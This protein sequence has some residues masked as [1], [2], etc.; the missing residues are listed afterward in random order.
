MSKPPIHWRQ[1]NGGFRE[2]WEGFRTYADGE[3]KVGY[4]VAFGP[5]IWTPGI[6]HADGTDTPLIAVDSLA[7]GQSVVQ[8]KAEL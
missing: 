1:K 5:L 7:S 6:M 4:V 8:G 2:L 3:V